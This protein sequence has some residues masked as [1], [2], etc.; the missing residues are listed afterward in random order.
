[1]QRYFAVNEKLE[2]CDSDLHHITNVMRMKKNNKFKIIY[3]YNEYECVINEIINKNIKFEVINKT[4]LEKDVNPKITL[5]VCLIKEQKIDYLLQKATELGVDF[6]I[7]MKSERSIIKIDKKNE[8]KKINRWGKICKEASEQSHRNSIP[9]IKNIID[10]KEIINFKEELNLI[11]TV[12][13]T[14]TS[15]KQ[16]LKDNSNC[17]KLLIVVG[18]EGGFSNNEEKLLIDNGFIS[19]SLGNNILRSETAPLYILSI[20]NYEFMR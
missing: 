2:L 15:I 11:F 10:I 7:P 1:M 6:I 12:N 4:L 20:I 3:D 9:K 17:D 8:D 16:V 5:A 18:P 13:E 19:T 14:S